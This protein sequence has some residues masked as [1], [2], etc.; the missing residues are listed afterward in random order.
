MNG[1][2]FQCFTENEAKNQFNKTVE[3]LGEYVAKNMKYAGDMMQLTKELEQPTIEEP[4]ELSDSETS[5]L[6]ITLWERKVVSYSVRLDYLESNL[7]AAYAVIWG[8]CSEAMRAKLKSLSN[9][10]D[11]DRDSDCV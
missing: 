4:E 7:K 6:K 9:F 10:S 5:K 11:R 2:V 3:A 1:N 8:Q